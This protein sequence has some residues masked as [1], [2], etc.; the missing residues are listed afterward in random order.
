MPFQVSSEVLSE[1]FVIPIGKAK[2]EL[3][4][5]DVTIVSYSKGVQNALEAADELK[6]IGVKAEVRNF[7]Y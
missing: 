6:S 3:E 4:G 7:L 2:I 5:S 1:D